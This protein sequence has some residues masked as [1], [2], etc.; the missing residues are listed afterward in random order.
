MDEK[1]LTVSLVVQMGSLEQSGTPYLI[2]IILFLFLKE[3]TCD[4]E[5]KDFEPNNCCFHFHKRGLLLD[6]SIKAAALATSV[7][8]NTKNQKLKGSENVPV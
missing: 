4:T 6:V 5:E 8:T 2:C 3:F 7:T 1:G